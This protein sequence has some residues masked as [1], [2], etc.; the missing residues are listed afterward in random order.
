MKTPAIPFLDRVAK[1]PILLDGAMG[2]E[3]YKRGVF[4]NRN[5][6]ATTLSDPKLVLQVHKDYI[7]AGSE[8]IGTNTF[9]ANRIKLHNAG[10]EDKVESINRAAVHL[11]REAA[12]DSVYVVGAVGPTGVTP[13]VA[14][15]KER[16][17][18]AAAFREQ[19]TALTAAGVDA[20][21]L[22]TFFH[23]DEIEVAMK[24]AREVAPD[25]PLIA[26]MSYSEEAV[27]SDGT[28][29]EDV[30]QKLLEWGADVV[31]AN[32]AEGPARLYHVAERIMAAREKAGGE[33]PPLMMSPNAGYPKRVGE[34]YLYMATPEYFA[35]YAMHFFKLGVNLVGGC[36]GS[37]PEHIRQMA[38]SARMT[39]G[40]RIQ[41]GGTLEQE[42]IHEAGGVEPWTMAEK[43]PLGRKIAR[44]KDLA[45]SVEIN[46]PVGLDP[47]AAIAKARLLKAAGI[48]VVNIPDNARASVR[49]SNSAL[50]K[51]LKDEVGI[52][53]I[54]HVCLR[55]RN[56][57]A[58]QAE[59]L[60]YHVMGMHN[61]VIITGDPPKMGDYPDATAVF[62]L[63]SIGLLRVVS[64]FNRGLD[65][66]GKS[67]K[68][69]TQFLMA[70]GAEPAATDYDREIRRLEQ[71]REAG[72]EFVMTQ[73]V[74]DPEVVDR[75]LNDIKHLDMPVLIGLLPLASYKNAEFL[76]NE[77]PGMSVPQN[78]RE[79]MQ[80]VGRG[81]AARQ[82][83]VRI[84]QEALQG[85][86]DRIAGCYI[87]PPF[88][89]V[90]AAI[91]ILE[92]VGYEKPTG[93]LD[94]WRE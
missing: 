85:V 69:C 23:L 62:D 54:L 84:A 12:G 66:A 65:P 43:S 18:I 77:V 26:S 71:K 92:V 2:T 48:D 51:R 24:A 39:G 44:G 55:D 7:A 70:C 75:F 49:M 87:M 60:G 4:I 25:V 30:V 28:G 57:I 40:G 37:S 93:W 31:G 11:A 27:V 38:G 79:R 89:R 34:R 45:V 19:I 29:P 10:L 80:K 9:G 94:N 64:R 58:T 1:G 88:G 47:A 82:E 35:V 20:I 52:D 56:F 76:H 13:S 32:C 5:F 21:Q 14:D 61:L 90:E 3:L 91:E 22:E 72:A 73:P 63:D 86:K 33:G 15:E 41:G 17:A 50:G 81:P 59:I 83:G 67:I 8:V 42:P 46:P 78:I 16:A 53:C 74:Y 6:E 36:C 68:G